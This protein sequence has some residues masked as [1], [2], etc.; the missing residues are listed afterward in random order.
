MSVRTKMLLL[1]FIILV[2]ICS[3]NQRLLFG[4][5]WVVL[6]EMAHVV[7][8]KIFGAGIFSIELHLTGVKGDIQGVEDLS[9]KEKV[10]IYM[11]GPLVNIAL[12]IALYFISKYIDLEWIKEGMWI[13]LGLGIFNLMPAYPLDG[14][15]IYEII[16]GEKFIFKTAKNIL[17]KVSFVISGILIVLFFLTVYIHKANLSLIL[18]AILI[19]YSAILEKKN[20][21]Y[22]LMGNLFKKRRRLIKKEYIENKNISVYYK[23]S[24]VKALTLIDGN[25]YNSFFILDEGLQLMGIVYEDELIEA[26]KEYGNISFGEYLDK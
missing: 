20:I 5:L 7:T 25:K 21:M 16:L 24:L 18:S 22:L 10:F 11:S 8:S 26:L 23:S 1:E 6:H 9:Y 12:F 2:V 17:V 13:N 19:T 15:R 4:L 3:F 14:A